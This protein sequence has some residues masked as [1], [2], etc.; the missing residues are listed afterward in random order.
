MKNTSRIFPLLLLAAFLLT[1]CGQEKTAGIPRTEM[2]GANPIGSQKADIAQSGVEIADVCSYFPKELVESA[3]GRPIVKMEVSIS[4]NA[5]DYYTG[6]KENYRHTPYGDKPGGPKV[7]VVHDTKDFARDRITNEK[8]GTKYET[9]SSIGMANFVMRN[10]V[11]KIWQTALALGGERYIRIKFIDDAVTGEDLVKI[12]TEFAKKI[13]GDS[14]MNST[15]GT[16][17]SNNQAATE[18]TGKNQATTGRTGANQQA[19]VTSFWQNIAG[20]KI[21]NAIAMMDASDQTK[22]MWKRNFATISTLKVNKIEEA[23]REEWTDNRQSF[24]VQ[25]HV[26]VNPTGKQLGWQNGMNYRWVTLTKTASGQWLV[27]E[28]ANNP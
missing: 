18:N 6:Y 22:A 23:F 3:I 12:A 21:D 27:H 11:K 17:Q 13:K 16:T 19:L 2:N 5:C 8:H 9:D 26:N 20:S 10:N 25:L 4:S 1:A 24:K 14:S 7:V 28:I 15:E